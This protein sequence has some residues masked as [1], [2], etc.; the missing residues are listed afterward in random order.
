MTRAMLQEAMEIELKIV[1]TLQKTISENR[2]KMWE[3]T[4]ELLGSMV[5]D[6]FGEAL[7]LDEKY[8]KCV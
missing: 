7:P 8:R 2:E 5:Q 3:H 4:L 6:E 1:R